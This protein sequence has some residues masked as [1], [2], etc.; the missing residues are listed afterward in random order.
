[1]ALYLKLHVMST[2]YVESFMVSVQYWQFF[3]LCCYTIIRN[4]DDYPHAHVAFE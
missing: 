2:I 4:L 3:G 1:M